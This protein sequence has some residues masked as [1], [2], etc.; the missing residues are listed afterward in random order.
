[1]NYISK[2]LVLGQFGLLLGIVSQIEQFTI[3]D[4]FILITGIGLGLWAI[5]AKR[6]SLSIFPEPQKDMMLIT[7]GPY[8][9]IRHPMYSALI[10]VSLSL[11]GNMLSLMMLLILILILITKINLEEQ[12]LTEKYKEYE[13]YKLHTARLVPSIY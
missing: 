5:Y 4:L 8:K 3:F 12:Y 1:M 7:S 13:A 11:T 2:L 9:Q 6:D 10:I